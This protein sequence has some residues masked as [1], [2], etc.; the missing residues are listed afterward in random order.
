[1]LCI[2]VTLFYFPLGRYWFLFILHV[3]P[4]VQGFGIDFECKKDNCARLWLCLTGSSAKLEQAHWQR[5][6]VLK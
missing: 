5:K 3:G 4:A 6:K 2:F 1:M